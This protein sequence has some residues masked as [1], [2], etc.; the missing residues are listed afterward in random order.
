[1]NSIIGFSDYGHLGT[2]SALAAKMKGFVISKKLE[3]CDIVYISPDRPSDVSPEDAV[4]KIIPILRKDA[5]LV[6]LCQVEPGFTRK[7]DWP[8]ERL[9]YQVETLKV[10]DEALDRAVNPERI[11]I[12]HGGK[13]FLDT[14][15]QKFISVFDCPLFL[16]SYES[17]ELAKIAINLYLVAQIET[18][19]KLSK[20]AE[21]VRANW[22]DIIPVLQTDKRIGNYAYL[23]PGVL[24]KH[25]QRDADMIGKFL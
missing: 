18:S 21:K 6:V 5:A 13:G 19:N 11:I 25:L 22:D 3:E 20:V 4:N 2:H 15:L 17:A 23:K 8:K 10:T 9:Y 24:G 1:M 14:N 16:M 12:G 7:I